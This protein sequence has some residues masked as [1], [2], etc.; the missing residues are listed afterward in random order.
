MKADIRTELPQILPN[1]E[2]SSSIT[3][4]QYI[5]QDFLA[6]QSIFY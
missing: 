2:G 6:H 1:V 3:R 4:V 5:S